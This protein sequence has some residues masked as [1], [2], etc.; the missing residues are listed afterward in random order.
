[1]GGGDEQVADIVLLL[2]VEADDPLASPV[3]YP[4]G[5]D[6]QPLDVAVTG[7]RDDHI[8]FLDEVGDVDVIRLNGLDLRPSGVAVAL[9]DIFQVILDEFEYTTRVLE[10]LAQVGDLFDDRL[11][12]LL[13]LLA[14]KLGE[15]AEGQV[16]D[17]LGLPLGE[18]ERRLLQPVARR[19]GRGRVTYG[20]DDG[21]EHAEGLQEA[22]QYV[23][24]L[25]CLGE[26]E[27]RAAQ[28]DLAAMV[29]VDL[30][31][32][33]EGEHPGHTVDERQHVAGEVGA[34]GGVLVELVEDYVRVRVPLE[35][36]NDTHALAVGLIADV[37]Y[38]IDLLVADQLRHVCDQGGLVHLVRQLRDDDGVLVAA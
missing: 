14:L 31:R 24:A 11:I 4:V 9:L 38:A 37:R 21:V 8:L 1:M 35:L 17:G 19:G 33:L 16:Q 13:D 22:L 5:G 29:D 12:L 2:L 23:R 7:H 26:Q 6:G 28:Y 10:D 18:L 27:A 30:Q 15:A 32:P 25:L 36:H 34:H 20:L 3:L